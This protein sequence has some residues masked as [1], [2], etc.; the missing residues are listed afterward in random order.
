MAQITDLSTVVGMLS[1]KLLSEKGQHVALVFSDTPARFFLTQTVA[2]LAHSAGVDVV[3]PEDVASLTNMSDELSLFSEK[4]LYILDGKGCKDFVFREPSEK[5]VFIAVESK[6][7]LPKDAA[8]CTT[9]TFPIEKPWEQKSRTAAWTRTLFQKRG[10]RPDEELVEALVSGTSGDFSRISQ[11]VEKIC[12]YAVD[13]P[14]VSLQQAGC[15][16]ELTHSESEWQQA[17]RLIWSGHAPEQSFDDHSALF[18]FAGLLRYH[19]QL[20]VVLS[21]AKDPLEELHKQYPK[22]KS[23]GEKLYLPKAKSLGARYFING[24]GALSELEKSAR[25]ASHALRHLWDMFIIN[26]R[27]HT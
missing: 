5:R 24:I 3:Y 4:K 1:E 7:Q 27:C 18:R 2:K 14:S 11:E 21:T 19:L 6:A 10:K 22:L 15:V 13:T 16:S 25:V 17:E 26:M 12:L 20:G 8:H 9:I 23:K